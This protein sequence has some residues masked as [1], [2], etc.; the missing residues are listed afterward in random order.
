M[1]KP[2]TPGVNQDVTGV[3]YAIHFGASGDYQVSGEQRKNE[4][5]I[6]LGF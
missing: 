6:S 1:Q 3:K 2:T 4:R 5:H